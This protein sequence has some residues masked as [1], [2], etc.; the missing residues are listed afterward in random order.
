VSSIDLV[1]GTFTLFAGA[2]GR[3]WAEAATRAA[4]ARG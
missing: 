1:D 3:E 4:R 2:S